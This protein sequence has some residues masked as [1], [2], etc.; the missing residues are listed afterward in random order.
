MSLA[1]IWTSIV[2]RVAPDFPEIRTVPLILDESARV[3]PRNWAFCTTGARPEVH[4]APSAADELPRDT[5]LGILW[6]EAMHALDG[7]Y[8]FKLDDG[9]L[10]RM[11]PNAE[12]RADLLAQVL[13]G[14]EIRYDPRTWLQC[15]RCHQACR[16]G[17]RPEPRPAGLR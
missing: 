12:H 4:I 15:V 17:D 1:A 13:F 11:E 8:R 14:V 5:L 10:E 9:N 16:R 2:R 3:P 7:L 6:H